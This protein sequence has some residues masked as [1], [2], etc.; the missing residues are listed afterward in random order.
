[1]LM[2]KLWCCLQAPLSPT[3]REQLEA[4]LRCQFTQSQPGPTALWPNG[5]FFWV[6]CLGL[7]L[8]NIWKLQL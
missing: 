3:Q 2:A 5:A 6:L 8:T 1:M 4:A 7:P